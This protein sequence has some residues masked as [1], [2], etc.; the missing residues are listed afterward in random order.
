MGYRAHVIIC[1]V[2]FKSRCDE[3]IL[4]AITILYYICTLSVGLLGHTDDRWMGYKT[5]M[6]LGNHPGI[7]GT[8][9]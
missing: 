8:R 3:D 1:G 5:S 4:G 7:V 9:C 6:V 2:N